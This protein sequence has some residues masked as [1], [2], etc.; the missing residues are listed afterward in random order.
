MSILVRLLALITVRKPITSLTR[1]IKVFETY[2][3][4][5]GVQK[6]SA[7]AQKRY[8]AEIDNNV[9]L[10]TII[11][12]EVGGSIAILVNTDPAAF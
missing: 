8:Q 5:C 3:K 12:N 11:R 6:A 9:P 4:P 1:V 2:Y 7:L 10:E